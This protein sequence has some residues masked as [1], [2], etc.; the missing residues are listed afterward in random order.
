MYIGIADDLT[1]QKPTKRRCRRNR[2]ALKKVGMESRFLAREVGEVG[3]K[4]H[5]RDSDG[6]REV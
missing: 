4:V 5:N 6:E 1:D 3:R 2:Y